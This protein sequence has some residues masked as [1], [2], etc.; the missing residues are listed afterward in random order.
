MATGIGAWKIRQPHVSLDPGSEEHSGS[1]E[2]KAKRDD[3]I[4]FPDG[5]VILQAGGIAF[6]VYHGL[7]TLHSEALADMFSVL[8]PECVDTLDECP[9]IHL[10]DHPGD[11]RHLLRVLFSAHFPFSVVTSVARLAH[12]YG[13][14]NIL[15]DALDRMKSCFSDALF[16]WAEADE[17]GGSHLMTYEETDAIAAVNIARLTN[18]TTMLPVALYICYQPETEAILNGV[19]RDDGTIEQ[20]AP[21]DIVRCIDARRI[22]VHDM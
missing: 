15:E 3:G 1:S 12:K 17:N 6:H 14:N 21:D 2:D 8:Q 9:V 22:L 5:N 4:W 16:Q 19:T 10:S 20:L 13:I 7:L 18:T 11:L